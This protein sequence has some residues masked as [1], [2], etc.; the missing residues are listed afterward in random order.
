MICSGRLVKQKS[1]IIL[2]TSKGW[3][4]EN[5]IWNIID[6]AV[7]VTLIG[8]FVFACVVDGVFGSWY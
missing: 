1:G 6:V 2:F 4:M 5:W 3:V 8:S 7:Y